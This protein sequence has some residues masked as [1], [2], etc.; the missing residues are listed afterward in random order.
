MSNRPPPLSLLVV[1]LLFNCESC[2]Y[3]SFNCVLICNK[4]R[5]KTFQLTV[6]IKYYLSIYNIPRISAMY[7]IYTSRKENKFSL[8]LVLCISPNEE[9]EGRGEGLKK[10]KHCSC[11]IHN[12]TTTRIKVSKKLKRLYNI[13]IKFGVPKRLK[14]NITTKLISFL[15]SDSW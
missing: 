6:V 13:Q 8:F 12:L 15:M 5:C 4:S 9:L 2:M 3:V 7:F 14:T 11:L 1:D 10:H